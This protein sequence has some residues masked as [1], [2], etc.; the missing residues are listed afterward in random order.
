VPL[1]CLGLPVAFRRAPAATAAL[2]VASVVVMATVTATHALAGYDGRYV[3]RLLD[4]QLTLSAAS[5][6][7]ITGWYAMLPFFVAVA[8][9]VVLAA[10]TSPL[11]A[12][13]LRGLLAGAVALGGWGL[14]LTFAP[15]E[16]EGSVLRFAVL[17]G[18]IAAAIA[19]AEVLE[20]PRRQAIRA[21]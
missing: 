5:L 4:R 10:A 12:P 20:R 19:A 2:A 14:L 15:V 16:T 21:A 9:A 3:D 17:L 6:V 8:A 18:V 7:G 11:R 13:T 1:L